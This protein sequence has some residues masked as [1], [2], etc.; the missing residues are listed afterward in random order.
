MYAADMGE[1]GDDALLA[2]ALQLSLQDSQPRGAAASE[3]ADAELDRAIRESLRDTPSHGPRGSAAVTSGGAAI[4]ADAAVA[5][6]DVNV[7]SKARA[8]NRKRRGKK[9]EATSR[10]QAADAAQHP[11][12]V[13]FRQDLRLHDNPALH[14]AAASGRPVVPVFVLEPADEEGPAPMGGASKLWLH[15]SLRAL[16]RSLREHC[17][18]RLTL[19]D[20]RRAGGTCG[21]LVALAAECNAGAIFFNRVCAWLSPPPRRAR[22]PRRRRGLKAH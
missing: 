22:P 14:A 16:D 20:G 4:P 3:A 19:L 1:G 10:A 13:W 21:A 17:A 9:R 6:G 18:S 15:H 2:L 11:V 8:K 5:C 12:L 7:Q